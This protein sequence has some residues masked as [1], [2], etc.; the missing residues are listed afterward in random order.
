[1]NDPITLTIV[2]LPAPQGSK[3]RMP[4]G[5]MV[6]GTSKTGRANLAAWRDAVRGECRAWLADHPASPLAE[7]LALHV[8]F[9]FPLPKGDAYRWHHVSAPDLDKLVRGVFDSL[10][11]GGMLADDRYVSELLTTKRYAQA[12][13]SI[14]ADVTIGPLG[15]QEA[16][17]R[18]Q[19]KADAA[20][21]RKLARAAS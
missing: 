13:E 6:D 4:N 12:G 20:E 15:W 1:M 10:V 14:G 19:A 8:T 3:T 21:A 11:Q 9:R 16:R 5:A 2:G 17:H 7:P 18:E